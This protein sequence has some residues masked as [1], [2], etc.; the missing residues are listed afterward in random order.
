MNNLKVQ[1]FF[2]LDVDVVALNNAGKSTLSNNDNAIATKKV[3]KHKRPYAYISGQAFGQWWRDTL[4]KQFSWELSPV[5]RESKTAFTAA[6]PIKYPDDDVFGYVK[7]AKEASVD[8]E[9]G[10]V[11]TNTKGKAVMEDITVTRIA[12]LK[13]SAIVSVAPVGIARNWSSMARQEGDAVPYFKEEYSAIMKGQFSL[14]LQQVGS[15]SFYNRTGFK[16]LSDNLKEYALENGCSEVPDPFV[17]DG[18]GLPHK[19]LQLPAELRVQRAIDVIQALKVISGGAMQTNNMGDITPKFIILALMPTGN[20][21]FGH[22]FSEKVQKVD[23]EEQEIATVSQY[24]DRVQLNIDGIKEVLKDYKKQITGQVFIG[25]RAGFMDEYAA[26]LK[27][28]QNL[29]AAYPLVSVASI[30]DALDGFC[31]QIKKEFN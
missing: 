23:V 26:E 25:V 8:E 24:G 15:F 19:L 1:G 2:L 17:L 12:P 20:H 5:L 6:N 9:S 10:E 11:K 30:G 31:E 22:V 13:K 27:E 29:G 28:L 14:D 4:Q 16:N 3:Y 7:A 21:P 18:K